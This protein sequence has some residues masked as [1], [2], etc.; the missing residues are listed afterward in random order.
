MNP[1][2]DAHTNNSL[3][4]AVSDI[5]RGRIRCVLMYS[6]GLDSTIAGHLLLSQGVEVTALHFVLP[7]GS[8]LSLTHEHIRRLAGALGV[9]LR[10]E[11]EGEE[12][13]ALSLIHI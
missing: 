12:F 5:S 9:A 2:S 6:G 7:F 8:G 1:L 11:E 10:I 3:Q 4:P 13:L